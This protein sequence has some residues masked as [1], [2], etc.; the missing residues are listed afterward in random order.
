MC[1]PCLFEL[2]FISKEHSRTK[3]T[4]AGLLPTLCGDLLDDQVGDS[5]CCVND[6]LDRS[7]KYHGPLMGL[8][9]PT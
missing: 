1:S 4:S 7:Y 5:P 3:T 9:P 2:C 6:T 8:G